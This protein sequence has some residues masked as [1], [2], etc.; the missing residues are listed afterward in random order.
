[1]QEN[2]YITLCIFDMTAKHQIEP[3][4][5]HNLRNWMQWEQ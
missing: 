5:F 3:Q 1:M 2:E 4:F